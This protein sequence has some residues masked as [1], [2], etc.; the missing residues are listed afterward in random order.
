MVAAIVALRVG[1]GIHFYMEGT[2]KLKDKKPFSGPFF[3]NAKGPLAEAF[4]GRVWDID[5][6]WRMN[7]KATEAHWKNYEEK[8][9]SHFGFDDKQKKKAETLVKN[10]SKRMNSYLG[11]K[12]DEID[13]YYK[14]LD[15]RDADRNVAYRQAMTSMQAHDARIES[16]RNAL[17]MPILT[18]VDKVWIDLQNDMN[19]IATDKQM[20]R[21]GVL[22]IGKVG[23]RFGDTEFMDAVVPY[24]DLII[25][26]CLITGLFTRVA[27]IAGAI[28]LAGV[29]ASQWPGYGGAPIFNQ[30]VEMLT[31]LALAA[32]GAGQFCGLDYVI[33][34]LRRMTRKPAAN[35]PAKNSAASRPAP[36]LASAKGA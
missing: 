32:L 7:S 13:E 24:F 11:S 17:K 27:A 18:F 20:L 14:Q 36:A 19:A 4:R 9:A 16:D 8:A 35:T 31:L 15:R 3:A 33:T 2:T 25:G 5:G 34:G 23:Q 12:R 10:Y 26:L 1:V 28:F 29:C 22:K 21:H 6:T 30:F